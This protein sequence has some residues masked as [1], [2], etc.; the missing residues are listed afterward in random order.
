MIMGIG[1]ILATVGQPFYFLLSRLILVIAFILYLLRRPVKVKRAAKKKVIYR[2]FE[3]PKF[4]L[5]W[6]KVRIKFD[7]FK[8]ETLKVTLLEL[9]IWAKIKKLLQKP[10]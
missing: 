6:P 4:K 2:K 8:L 3:L 5:R 7:I 1:K 9:T 10:K